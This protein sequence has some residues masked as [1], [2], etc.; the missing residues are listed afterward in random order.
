[1]IQL[2]QGQRSLDSTFEL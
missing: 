1:M 2:C